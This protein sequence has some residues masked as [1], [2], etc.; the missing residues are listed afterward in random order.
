MQVADAQALAASNKTSATTTPTATAPTSTSTTS[1]TPTSSTL[2]AS[3]GPDVGGWTIP[4]P[5]PVSTQTPLRSLQQSGSRLYYISAVKGSDSTG[6]IYFWDGSRI[7]DSNGRSTNS[8]GQSYGTDPMNPSSAVRP[9]KRWAYVAPRDSATQD[10]GSRG[11]VGGATP[12]MRAGYP[13]WWLF[14]RGE[15]FD[16]AADLLSF[17]RE[18]NPSA[19]MVNESLSVPGGRS[20]TER[21]IVG[22]YGDICQARPR[23]IH[24][25]LGFLSRFTSPTTAPFKNVA[26]LSLHFDGHSRT[27]VGTYSGITLLGQTV[28]ST[29]VLF[30]DVW[31]DGATV[32]IGIANAGQITF[33]RSLITD[34]FVNDG[35][36]V[37]GL[38]YEGSRDGRLRIEES[39]LMRNG[40]S[41]GDPKTMAWPPSGTQIWDMYSRNMYINGQINSLQS[42][43]FDSVSMI[44]ASGDQFRNGFKVERN[45]FYQGYVA[46]G[47]HG[48]YADAAG[49]TGS[50]LDNVL[51]RF[52]GSGT[53]DNRGH[54]GW[55]LQLGGGA[56]AVEVARNIVTGAQHP[57]ATFALQLMPLFQ[58]CNVPYQYATRSNNIHHN[59]FDSG[60]AS[61]AIK[62]SD[63]TTN[64]CYG[65]VL[66]G[67][68]GNVA[69]DNT[70]INSALLA[71]E[72][73]TVGAAVGTAT[74]TLYQRNR[75][76]ADRA[77]A[78]AALGWTAPDRTLKTYLIAN[79][80]NVTSSDG[81]PEYFAQ[82]T[83]QR[84]GQWREE[85]MARPMVNYIRGGFGMA[86]LPQP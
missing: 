18:T 25:M 72:Y 51:Q 36:H 55:G 62:V 58:D 75:M 84:R 31:V 2:T 52:T 59:I 46:M 6:E 76:Y 12:G 4:V 32:N 70:L 1:S 65:L 38:Y 61:A 17:E 21:Q 71:S 56:Y 19:T 45:F 49:A 39:I 41:H 29:D 74:D 82:A 16:L 10:I 85:W 13:D 5:T 3:C 69:S 64:T 43:L 15:T 78:A 24:P 42:G 33:R 37:Q 20:A 35:V 63:G 79:G 47:A 11:R 8:A 40:F 27:S 22:A 66:P 68:R 73:N 34:A 44:G 86:A 57:A 7:I 60:S 53:N 14:N 77:Q 48:G 81:F 23:F 28:A 9:F 50:M 67:V 26:Y 54:P 30:E 83:A 80:V